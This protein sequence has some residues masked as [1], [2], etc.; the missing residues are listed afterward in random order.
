MGH[1]FPTL[2]TCCEPGCS[3]PVDKPRS[4][5]RCAEHF[6]PP[7]YGGGSTNP[8]RRKRSQPQEGQTR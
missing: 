3:R 6:T 7:L 2:K 4:R 5:V 1:P 8:G